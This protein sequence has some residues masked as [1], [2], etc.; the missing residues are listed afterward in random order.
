ME[1]T[2]EIKNGAI[3]LPTYL[4]KKLKKTKIVLDEYGN[5]INIHIIPIALIAPTKTSLSAKALL[6]LAG[7]LKGKLPVD[8]IRWQREIRK[9]WDRELPKLK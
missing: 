4:Q 8:P 9:E 1:T 3:M 2:L 5:N 6:K 7:S